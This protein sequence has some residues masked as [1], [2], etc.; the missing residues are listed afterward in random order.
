MSIWAHQLLLTTL[1]KISSIV[2][3]HCWLRSPSLFL[4]NNVTEEAKAVPDNIMWVSQRR[5][6]LSIQPVIWGFNCMDFLT[7]KTTVLR[8]TIMPLA[9]FIFTIPPTGK[10]VIWR[11]NLHSKW[12]EIKWAMIFLCLKFQRHLC[13]E[14]D[15]ALLILWTVRNQGGLATQSLFVSFWV[16]T[17]ATTLW[18]P[19]W[20]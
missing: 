9:V 12:T 14:S 16:V 20:I 5:V 19:R 11:N 17:L 6:S 4:L 18:G 15:I 8:Y 13:L 7:A 1:A 3:R 2:H 10:E